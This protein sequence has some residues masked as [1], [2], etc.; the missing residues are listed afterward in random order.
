[1]RPE[2]KEAKK[3][4]EKAFDLV[5]EDGLRTLIVEL[6]KAQLTMAVTMLFS[7]AAWTSRFMGALENPDHAQ[8]QLLCKQMDKLI[9]SPQAVKVLQDVPDQLIINYEQ[10][11]DKIP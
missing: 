5:G 11:E 4:L 10:V 6:S 2:M 1:M 3:L 9:P 8:I 7:D